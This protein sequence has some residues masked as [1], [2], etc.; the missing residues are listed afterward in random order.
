MVYYTYMTFLTQKQFQELKEQLEKEA[1][2]IEARLA[3]ESR[4]PDFGND[5]GHSG[6]EEET[7]ETEEFANSLGTR[8]TLK[9]RLRDIEAALEKITHN[10][11]GICEKCKKEISL[12]LLNVDPESRLCKDCKFNR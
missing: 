8:E 11:Y 9:E 12:A 1:G 4:T 10:T 6:E 7:N 2:E 3:V 5:T